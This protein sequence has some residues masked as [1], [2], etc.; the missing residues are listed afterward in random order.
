MSIH[1]G[2][3]DEKLKISMYQSSD[4]SDAI[5]DFMNRDDTHETLRD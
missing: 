3:I 2:E 4:E 1:G 5:G